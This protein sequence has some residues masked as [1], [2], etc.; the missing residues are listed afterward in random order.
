MEAKIRKGEKKMKR[1]VVRRRAVVLDKEVWCTWVLECEDAITKDAIEAILEE[2]YDFPDD[3]YKDGVARYT[4]QEV[5]RARNW[6]E[7]IEDVPLIRMERASNGYDLR[8]EVP[9]HQAVS[10]EA[11][12]TT[13][14]PTESKRPETP[15]TT[16]NILAEADF[17]EELKRM[18]SDP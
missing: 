4:S 11:A 2:T 9:E 5:K 16:D 17:L 7:V 15:E 10:P 6:N 12:M 8:Y 13:L 1:F 14:D 3:V 18:S